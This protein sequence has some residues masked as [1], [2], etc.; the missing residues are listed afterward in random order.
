MKFINKDKLYITKDTNG[1]YDVKYDENIVFN[2]AAYENME[3]KNIE[4]GETFL[5]KNLVLCLSKENDVYLYPEALY[6]SKKLL[7]EYNIKNWFFVDDKELTQY[8]YT[9]AIN[10]VSNLLVTST[11]TLQNVVTDLAKL[12]KDVNVFVGNITQ[13]TNTSLPEITNT[14]KN[15]TKNV[16]NLVNTFANSGVTG[17]VLQFIK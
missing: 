14:T 5:Y 4:T 13:V 6:T 10:D 3:L 12:S 2:Y 9:T 17:G 1:Y 11:N 16:S 8:N 15:I 7:K